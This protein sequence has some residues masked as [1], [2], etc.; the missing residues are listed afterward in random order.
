MSGKLTVDT[1]KIL[2]NIQTIKQKIYPAK[3]CAV[4]KADCYGVGL[5]LVKYINPYVDYYA[6]S[7][8]FEAMQLNNLT[9]KDILVLSPPNINDINCLNKFIEL[10]L[11]PYNICITVDNLGLLKKLISSKNEYKIHIAVN[12]GMNRYGVSY[13][14]FEKML[15]IISNHSNI[16]LIGVFSHFYKNSKAVMQQ[17]YQQFIKFISLAK[18]YNPNIICHISNSGG[19]DYALDMVRIGIGLYCLDD[20]A[21][22]LTSNIISVRTIDAGDS[23]SYNAHFIAA[24]RM[25][26]GV[27]PIGYA[28]GIMRKMRGQYVIVN[29]CYCKIIGDICMDC[30]MIDLSNVK[31]VKIGDQ[32]TIFGKS[33]NKF[34]NVCNIAKRCGTISYELLTRIGGRIIKEYK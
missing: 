32:V 34:I 18:H 29:N 6:V 25:K 10:G 17:Q 27:V 21:L 7:N 11:K 22:K 13:F 26:I 31:R 1:L 8:V 28:D 33:G 2:D 12:T 20:T 23:V 14:E 5:D 30:F 9:D 4:V 16:K 15:K 24:R 19:T 3:F